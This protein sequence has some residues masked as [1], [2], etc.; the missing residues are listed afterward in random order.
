MT[1][2]FALLS[3]IIALPFLGMLFVLT[4]KDEENTGKN[5]LNV[6][7][8]TVLANITL[9]WRVFM[10]LDDKKTT[11]QLFEYLKWLPRPQIDITLAV[12][13]FSLL[14]ILA[15]H[16]AILIGLVGVKNNTVKQKSQMVFTLL[17]LSMITG[18]F[19]AEDIFSFYI[20]FEAMLLPL[21][22]LLGISGGIKRQELIYRFFLYNFFG[23]LILFAATMT[24]YHYYGTMTLQQLQNLKIKDEIEFYV[25]GAIFI[26]FLSR[27]PIW[28]FHYWISS[29][30]SG[31]RNPLVFIICSV[32]PLTGIYAFI[33]FLPSVSSLPVELYSTWVSIIGIITMLFISLI[34]FINK[35][36]QYKI[37][38]YITVCYILYL[39]GVYTLDE[40]ILLNIGYSAFS[41]IIIFAALEILSDYIYRK[42]DQY[43]S[44]TLGAL[45]K[46]K[47]LSFAYSYLTIAAVGMPLSAVFINNFLIL[48]KLLETNLRM[49]MLLIGTLF[50]V[51]IT[52]LQEL[53]RLKTENSSCRM[54]KEDDISLALFAFMLAIMFILFMSFIRPLWFVLDA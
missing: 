25:W 21:F 12:D 28:P 40:L 39:I 47:R 15:V 36:S 22:M 52:L 27:I 50:M 44:G 23:A 49:G 3:L 1:S 43:G 34:G 24:L 30:N 41:F 45:C 13:V 20:F 26:S 42:E 37:F 32:M 8:F 9:I 54:K 5:A 4:A 7:I 16:L 53:H 31:I 11:L 29:I 38:S 48:S 18:F 51:G 14:L 10:L 6:C 33:R 2:P 19:V 35:D 17:F 46:V